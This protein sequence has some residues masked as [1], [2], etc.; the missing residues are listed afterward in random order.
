M[1]MITIAALS[2]IAAVSQAAP[3]EPIDL[4]R[5]GVMEA[6]ERESPELHRKIAQIRHLAT[7]MPCFTDDF[8]R[9]LTVRFEAEDAGCGVMLMTSY[10]SKRRLQFTLGATR[11]AT[12]VELDES[13]NRHVPAK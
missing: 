5:P 6:V 10:P 7:R 2:T 13:E 1:R 8:K 3:L 11:Y 4:D 12:V 9:T